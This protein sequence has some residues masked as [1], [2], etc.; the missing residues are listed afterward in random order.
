[1]SRAHV[2]GGAVGLLASAIVISGC[3]GSAPRTVSSTSTSTSAS[4]SGSTAIRSTAPAGGGPGPASSPVGASPSSGGSPATLVGPVGGPVPRGFKPYSATFVSPAEGWSLGDAPCASPPCTSVVR[5][6]DGGASWRG[7]P[8]PRASIALLNETGAGL[9]T[10][11]FANARDGWASGNA[12]Y[13]THDGGGTWRRVPLG[14]SGSV[15]S[16]LGA[17]GGEV[18]ASVYGCPSQ[19]GSHCSQTT[20]VYASP[21][22]ADRWAPVSDTLNGGGLPRLVVVQGGDWYL[23]LPE[24]IYHGQGDAMARRL[25]NPC[26]QYG[27]VSVTPALAVADADH[28]DAM[29]AS[30]GAGGSTEYQLYG[31]TDGGQH[32]NQAGPRSRQPSNLEGL[33]DNTHGVLLVACSSGGSAILRSTNDGTTLSSVPINAPS[34]GIP[35]SELGFTTSTHAIAVL[36]A[37]TLYLTHDSG[38]TWSPVRF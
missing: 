30:G 1:M 16:G 15:I 26:P 32:W 9:T 3:S 17:G 25:P 36:Q 5:T 18:Y 38:Q 7:I 11:R 27:A 22:G 33:A 23:P 14:R 10:L 34:G 12:L 37:S 35:W 21:A 13:A 24:G 20:R 28:L 31:T 29:C 19:G 8:A 6:L 4:P 2:F